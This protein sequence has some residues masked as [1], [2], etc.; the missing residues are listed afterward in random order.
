MHE[1]PHTIQRNMVVKPKYST[2]GPI[3]TIGCPIKFSETPSSIEMGAP[4]YG[5]H[6]KMILKEH[7]YS[8]A[9]IKS[10]YADGSVL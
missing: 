9:E 8:E 4:T 7:G 6:T 10:L 5:Q 2:L 3:E 1:D